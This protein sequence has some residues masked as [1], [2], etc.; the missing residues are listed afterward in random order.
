VVTTIASAFGLTIQTDAVRPALI[1]GVRAMRILLVL[2][3]C[4][5][6]IDA[7]AT[8]A[9]RIFQEAPGVHILATSREAMRVEGEHAY[10]LPPLES[11]SPDGSVSAAE[12]L[13]FPAV[14]L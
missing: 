11:P 8:L 14:K 5:H 3:N 7:C 2:D 1:S 12:A 10:W 9:E 13:K 4:E 6:V